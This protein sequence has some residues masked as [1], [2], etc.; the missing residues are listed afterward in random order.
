MDGLRGERRSDHHPQRANAHGGG[1]DTEGHADVGT[2]HTHRYPKA[3][4][5]SGSGPHTHLRAAR[6]VLLL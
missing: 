3:H 5:D 2:R 6:S 1:T 4:V